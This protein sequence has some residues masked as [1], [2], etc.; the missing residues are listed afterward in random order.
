M[1]KYIP[2]LF[3]EPSADLKKDLN[4]VKIPVGGSQEKRVSDRRVPRVLDFLKSISSEDF[5]KALANEKIRIKKLKESPKNPLINGK[6]VVFT[7]FFGDI[8]FQLEDYIYD[9]GGGY[10]F[11]NNFFH[12]RIDMQNPADFSKKIQTSFGVKS[13][14]LD[15]S[16]IPTFIWHSFCG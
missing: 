9:Q 8:D 1:L 7:G 13:T 2:T 11:N 5:T 14:G 15:R 4:A 6:T 10:F 3:V 12:S 16:R